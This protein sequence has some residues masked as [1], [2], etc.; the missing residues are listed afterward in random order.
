M[1]DNS[2]RLGKGLSSLLGEKKIFSQQ[3]KDIDGDIRDLDINSITK[4]KNQP[5]KRFNREQLE[6][7]ANSI[8]EFGILQ[9]IIV[10]PIEIDGVKKYQIVAGERRFRACK[11][12]NL[13]T[14]PAIIKDFDEN[15]S[16]SLSI[17]EN[18][19]RED[20]NIVEEA[21]AYNELINIYSYTQN[22]L[23]MKLG[24]SRSHVTNILRLLRLPEKVLNYLIENKLEMGHARALINHEKAEEL[25]DYVVENKLSVRETEKLVKS[26]IIKNKA[27]PIFVLNDLIIDK[28]RTLKDKLE[29][30]DIAI[31]FNEKKQSGSIIVKYRNLD[32]LDLF[33]NKIN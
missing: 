23:A 33:L 8:K 11:M 20:L 27:K 25:A 12:L 6:E 18:I 32:E 2:N 30:F 16:F 1:I 13:P 29:N 19:Q 10:R 9:P 5:R 26:G 31:K 22:D 21:I 28:E 15:K 3:N 17:I 4:N 24:K 7:L 14:I